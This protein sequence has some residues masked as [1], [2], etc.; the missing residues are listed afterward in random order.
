MKLAL[1]VDDIYRHTLSYP[2]QK[3]IQRGVSDF[4]F[5]ALK[6]GTLNL[7]IKNSFQEQILG[8]VPNLA[9]LTL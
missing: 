6:D 4:Q 5:K 8:I 1:D 9:P 7:I 2:M 3:I